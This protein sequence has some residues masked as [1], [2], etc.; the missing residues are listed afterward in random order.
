MP[1]MRQPVRLHMQDILNIRQQVLADPNN[2]NGE[3]DI[4]NI[5]YRKIYVEH[6]DFM[7]LYVQPGDKFKAGDILAESNF[8]HNGNINIGKNLLTGVMVYYGN[9]YED[10]IVISDR[11]V[12]E[13]SLTSVHFEDL[14]FTISPQQLL[15]SLDDK[16]Y[17]PLPNEFETVNLGKPY[18]IMKRL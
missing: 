12:N 16:K 3:A 2:D 1:Y 10:G 11:L 9:N 18:A 14:S 17:K 7:N 6:M 4:F 8:C 15:L 5:A 13:D